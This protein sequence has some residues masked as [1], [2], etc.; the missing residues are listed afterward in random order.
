MATRSIQSLV[1][2]HLPSLS[3]F[4]DLYKHFHAHPEL[5]EQESSTASKIASF[6]TNTFPDL[7]IKRSIGGHG[8]AAILRN[9]PGKTVLLRADMDALPI[10]EQTGLPYASTATMTDASDGVIKPVMH[11]CGHDLHV[12]CLLAATALLISARARWSGTLIF[13]FQP[14]EERHTGAESMVADGLYDA[15][16]HNVPIPDF[17]LGQHVMPYRTGTT[18]TCPGPVMYASNSLRV[19]VYGRGGHGSMPHRTLDPVVIA[20]GI[21]LKLQTI[22]ARETTPGERAVVTVGAF[23]AGNVDNVIPETAVLKI[24]IRSM[25]TETR[26]KILRSVKRIVEAECTAGGCEKA[27]LVEHTGSMP[28]TVND[29]DLTSNINDAFTTHFGENAHNGNVSNVLG[30]EDFSIL[31]TAVGKPSCYWFIGGVDGKLWDRLEKEGKLEEGVP[32]NHS[33]FFAPVVQPSLRVGCEALAVGALAVLG[34]K[35]EGR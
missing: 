15:S 30:S 9:G 5:S 32:I 8:I 17:V 26:D 20:S 22:V 1:I 3:P 19:T 16:R 28:L 34:I 24:N 7:T 4:E 11:A 31:A 23:N 6:L 10:K 33:P 2:S 14:A 35:G 25:R 27:P 13:L 21:V 18:A 29:E 12:T